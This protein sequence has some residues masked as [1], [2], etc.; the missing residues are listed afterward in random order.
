[1]I[2]IKVLLVFLISLECFSSNSISLLAE[3]RTV[4]GLEQFALTFT[5]NKVRIS[6]NSNFLNKEL[7]IYFLGLFTTEMNS[8]LENIY[9]ILYA[10][11]VQLNRID[12]INVQVGYKNDASPHQI[13][14]FLNNIQTVRGSS[15]YLRLK[16]ILNSLVPEENNWMKKDVIKI[17]RIKGD[18]ILLTQ[19]S[20][21]KS[22][23]NKTIHC[24]DRIPC[25]IDGYGIFW[26]NIKN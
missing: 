26:N 16:R 12:K 19:L 8:N 14:I 17:K 4:H 3:R 21:S 22:N 7:P 6:R 13:E 25:I 24:L 23:K 20:K 10:D 2:N 5:D 15:I 11:L 1:M 9:S 18:E